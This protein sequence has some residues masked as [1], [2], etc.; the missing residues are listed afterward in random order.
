MQFKLPMGVTH[1]EGSKGKNSRRHCCCIHINCNICERKRQ[2]LEIIGNSSIMQLEIGIMALS[3]ERDIFAICSFW[4]LWTYALFL[5]RDVGSTLLALLGFTS[6]LGYNLKVV[7]YGNK[8]RCS[9]INCE[10][11][12]ACWVK[13]SIIQDAIA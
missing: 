13:I 8:F 7:R 5:E 9:R 4:K 6:I 12:I 3:G 2:F 11:W 10:F 1:K